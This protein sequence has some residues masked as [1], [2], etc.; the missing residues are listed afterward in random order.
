MP[1]KQALRP[2]RKIC[3]TRRVV[4]AENM[5]VR[6]LGKLESAQLLSAEVVGGGYVFWFVDGTRIA[7]AGAVVKTGR[8]ETEMSIVGEE[9]IVDVTLL[10]DMVLL[11][12]KD[13]DVETLIPNPVRNKLGIC[14]VA[15][16]EQVMTYF[17]L[18]KSK[19]VYTFLRNTSPTS[20]RSGP[21]VSFP[22][23]LLAHRIPPETC[24]PR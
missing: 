16:E 21:K 2:M 23:T 12:V 22:M 1:P 24:F 18:I 3:V 20:D 6:E 13:G 19:I 15:Q 11:V 10:V 9:E 4:N 5:S 8:G 7:I 14:L 17:I